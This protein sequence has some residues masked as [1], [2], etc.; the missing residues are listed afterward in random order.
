MEKV[1]VWV[2]VGKLEYGGEWF[3]YSGKV[4]LKKGDAVKHG[5]WLVNGPKEYGINYDEYSMYECEVE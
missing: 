4:F 5:E 2:V 3:E 1:Q